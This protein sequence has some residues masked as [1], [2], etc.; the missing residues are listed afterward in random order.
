MKSLL[1]KNS[2]H[3]FICTTE[4]VL[5]VTP[6]LSSFMCSRTVSG[7]P[8]LPS[9]AC[10]STVGRPVLDMESP[11]LFLGTRTT[12]RGSPKRKRWNFIQVTHSGLKT[13]MWTHLWSAY[14]TPR[15]PIMLI[16]TLFAH[17]C[18]PGAPLSPLIPNIFTMSSRATL[19]SSFHEGG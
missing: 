7:R 10:S 11:F 5:G 17:S 12:S 19:T 16:Y 8:Q 15:I 18:N 13:V 14:S 3:I 2:H 9:L 6:H 4:V 1:L